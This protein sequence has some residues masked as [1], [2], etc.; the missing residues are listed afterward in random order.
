VTIAYQLAGCPLLP[1]SDAAHSR[2]YKYG[3]FHVSVFPS[4]TYT[5]FISRVLVPIRCESTQSSRALFRWSR[6][7][8]SLRVSEIALDASQRALTLQL[9]QKDGHHSPYD[10][11][12]R[13]AWPSSPLE[14]LKIAFDRKHANKCAAS[15]ALR[16]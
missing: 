5:L 12:L 1:T 13:C 6:S 16:A 3:I 15:V 7:D 4:R 14:N 11:M 8:S 9:V 10:V 2:W